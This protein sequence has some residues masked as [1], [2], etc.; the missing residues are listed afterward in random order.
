MADIIKPVPA[1]KQYFGM[2]PGQTMVQFLAELKAL[3][4]E[5]KLELARGAAKELGKE[6]ENA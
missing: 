6:L 1:I 3:T 2:L 4:P 5:E